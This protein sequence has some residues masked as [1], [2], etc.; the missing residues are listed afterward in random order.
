M[1]RKFIQSAIIALAL[2]CLPGAKAQTQEVDLG[3]K[4]GF[5]TDVMDFW[6]GSL[7]L[8]HSYRLQ[9]SIMLP[10]IT[11]DYG[12]GY[13]SP[14]RHL[15]RLTR[16]YEYMGPAWYQRE[17]TIPK[18]WEGKRIFMY[19]ERVH[20]LSSIVVDTKE[21]SKIDY[22]S[23]PHNHD[24]TQYLTPGKT[25]LIT[26]CIDNRYQYDT[27]KWDH[28]HTEFTQIN[29][30]GILGEMKLKAVDPVYTEDMQLYPNVTDKSVRVK[31]KVNNFTKKEV[32]G[33]A[34]FTITGD[35]YRLTH[36]VP[37]SGRDEAI[38][39]DQKHPSVG[40]VQPEPLHGGV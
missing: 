36:E 18:E 35:N 23:V 3:G 28:A 16:V 15:D 1:N 29:W 12:I 4:W 26:V 25:H 11:D 32:S 21:V 37:V 40:R 38:T 14:Y 19:F 20:W 27:H 8:R 33:K 10:G 22:V 7:G 31:M 17:I 5:Q 6:R 24:L 34:V 2:G 9:E 30:N 13:K 39:I